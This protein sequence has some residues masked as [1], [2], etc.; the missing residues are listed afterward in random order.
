MSQHM[1]TTTT[2]HKS[3]YIIMYVFEQTY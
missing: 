1:Q 3:T 2:T